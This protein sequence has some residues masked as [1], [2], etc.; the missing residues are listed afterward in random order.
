[1]R[2]IVSKAFTEGQPYTMLSL[3]GTDSS[4][5]LALPSNN[6]RRRTVVRFRSGPN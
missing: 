5:S 4:R 3:G 1:M 2:R 6:V